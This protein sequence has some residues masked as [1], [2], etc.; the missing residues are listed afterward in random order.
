MNLE[1]N[2]PSLIFFVLGQTGNAPTIDKQNGRLEERKIWTSTSLHDYL[3]F[4]H[5]GQVFLIERTRQILTTGKKNTEV[6][7][8]VTSLYS[9]KAGPKE[10]LRLVRGQWKIENRLHYVRDVTFDEDRS[11][12]RTGNGPHVMASIRNIAISLL[13]LAGAR[14]IAPA[15]R[16]C[17]YLGE[18]VA[19][20]IGIRL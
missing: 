12:I 14:Y 2:A 11:R 3:E 8:G 20:L 13:R 7:Y 15:L 10:I 6:I 17:T 16:F 9:E 19:R 4:P 5:V 1:R 18:K